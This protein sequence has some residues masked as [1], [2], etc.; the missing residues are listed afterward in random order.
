MSARI[1]LLRGALAQLLDAARPLLSGDR[2]IRAAENAL[3]ATAFVAPGTFPTRVNT[4]SG[5]VVTL[6]GMEQ[7]RLIGSWVD[8][9]GLQLNDWAVDGTL[10]GPDDPDDFDLVLPED[11]L[12]LRAV[13]A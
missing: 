8:R 12:L 11:T 9:D 4:R 5:A 3:A 2:A 1:T 6:Y 7:G 13:P 10:F